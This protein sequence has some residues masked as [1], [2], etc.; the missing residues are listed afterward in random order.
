[1]LSF[2]LLCLFPIQEKHDEDAVVVFSYLMLV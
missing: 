1:M 2:V